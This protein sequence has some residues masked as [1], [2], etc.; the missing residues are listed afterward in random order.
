ML[1]TKREDLFELLADPATAGEAAAELLEHPEWLTGRPPIELMIALTHLDYDAE[2]PV[3]ELARAWEREPVCRALIAA[4]RDEPD[5][6]LREHGAWLLK[7]LS[8][9]SAWPS[10]C[11]LVSNEAESSG[12]RRWLLEAIERLVATRA[13]G[14]REVGDLVATFAVHSDP[15]LRDGVIGIIAVLDRT[16]DKR[17]ILMQILRSD[18]DEMVLSSAIHALVSMLP[19]ELDPVVTERLLGHPSARV[20]RSVVD[21]IDRA[22]RRAKG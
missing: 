4:L 17:R 20:Q 15:S 2:A 12:V 10:I 14:W 5:N 21:F 9:P 16:E 19:V 13:V 8:A 11:E 1:S 18:D 7:H 22:K 6:K 3:F